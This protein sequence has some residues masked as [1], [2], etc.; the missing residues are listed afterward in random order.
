MCDNGEQC[1]SMLIDVGQSIYPGLWTLEWET[2]DS[3]GWESRG[4]SGELCGETVRSRVDMWGT[5]ES[6]VNLVEACGISVVSRGIS[7]GISG[8]SRGRL[9]NLEFRGRLWNL[10]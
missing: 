8:Q 9:W 4:D 5:V 1:V 3:G 6:P 2:V 7:C 10:G